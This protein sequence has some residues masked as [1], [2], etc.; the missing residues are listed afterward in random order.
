M[1]HCE[2]ESGRPLGSAVG[3]LEQRRPLTST[4][5]AGVVDRARV[6]SDSP[7]PCR[8]CGGGEILERRARPSLEGLTL[9]GLSGR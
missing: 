9:A 8:A 4:K 3:D 6:R 2:V 1:T 7:G 5:E